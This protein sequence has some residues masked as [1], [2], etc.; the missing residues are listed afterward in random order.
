M[1]WMNF[2]TELSHPRAD[3]KF[4]DSAEEKHQKDTLGFINWFI[5]EKQ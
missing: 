3:F 1:E 4:L 2:K 5:Q